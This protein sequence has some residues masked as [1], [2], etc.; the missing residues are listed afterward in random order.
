M[1]LKPILTFEWLI[2]FNKSGPINLIKP[3]KGRAQ[4]IYL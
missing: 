4:D 1:Y 2:Q 3:I